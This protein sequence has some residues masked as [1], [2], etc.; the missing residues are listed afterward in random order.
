MS[1]T[2]EQKDVVKKIIKGISSNQITTLGGYAGTGKSTIIKVILQIMDK[3]GFNFVPCAYTGKAA[4]VLRKK[5]MGRADTIHG[6]IYQAYTNDQQ[7][8]FW[9]LKSKT[10]FDQEKINGFIVDEASMVSKEIHEDLKSYGLPIIYV[11]DHGQLEPIGGANFNLMAEPMYTLEQVHRNAGEIAFFANHLRNGNVAEK[12]DGGNKV[13]LVTNSAVKSTHLSEVDQVI[14]AFNKT[15][16]ELNERVRV[17]KKIQYAYIARGEKIIC[18][19]NNKKLG[20]FNGMQGIV[21]KVLKDEKFTFVSDGI[22][23]E[24]IPY[25][26]DQFGQANNQFKFSETA[27]P[28]DYGYAITCHKA[29]GDE[30]NNVIVYEQPC[31][32]WDHTRWSYTAASRAKFE[33]IWVQSARFTPDYL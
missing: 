6:T 8:V 25:I 2:I 20:L 28:F 27:N 12:F 1:L 4:N 24:K 31:D 29:Q 3:K 26:P 21:K 23:Y 7:E 16:V 15:R 13:K 33:L 9:E 32:K 30:W 18:L 10:S 22:L 11:G 19:R 14:C 17:E 5:G